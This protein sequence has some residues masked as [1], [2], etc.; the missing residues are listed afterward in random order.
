MNAASATWDSVY[1]ELDHWGD[2]GTPATLWWR[3]DDATEATK[4]LTQ[5]AT[6]TAAGGIPIGLAVIPKEARESLPDV[7]AQNQNLWPM[8]HGFSHKN[9]APSGHKKQELGDHRPLSAI[10]DDLTLGLRCL[11]AYI[12]HLPVLV[13]PWNRISNSVAACIE[14]L[15]FI[16]LS[17][18]G[19]RNSEP[20]ARIVTVNNTHIDL[21][22]WRGSRGFVGETQ[23]LEMLLRHLRHRRS[24]IVDST[25]ATGFLSHHLVHDCETWKFID[26]VVAKLSHHPAALWLDPRAVFAAKGTAEA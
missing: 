14:S 15:G 4:A 26:R 16:G 11:S 7:L 9:H 21:I 12:R 20:I 2:A 6:A 24:G 25:E 8:V 19:A 23:A 13:P 5:L 22:D 10:K 3:D 1:A 18:Y 17:T